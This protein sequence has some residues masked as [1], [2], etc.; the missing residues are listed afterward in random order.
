MKIWH[1]KFILA[2]VSKDI[3]KGMWAEKLEFTILPSKAHSCKFLNRKLRKE[4]KRRKIGLWMLDFGF[5]LFLVSFLFTLFY[6]KTC[7]C[8]LWM[9]K[10]WIATFLSTHSFQNVL[11]KQLQEWI[12]DGRFSSIL[13]KFSLAAVWK[14]DF[15]RKNW[16][17]KGL[18]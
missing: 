12:L 17:Y 10:L 2:A 14:G 13:P 15:E 11:F 16:T 1:P 4:K 8:E 9:V 7:N 18:K 5:L 3:L 6:L